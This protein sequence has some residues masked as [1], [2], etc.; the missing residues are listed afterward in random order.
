LQVKIVKKSC[1]FPDVKPYTL[2]D[3]YN[4]PELC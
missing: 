2:T 1:L 3:L 4:Y